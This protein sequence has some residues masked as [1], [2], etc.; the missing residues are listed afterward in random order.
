MPQRLSRI[1]ARNVWLLCISLGGANTV[2]R[3]LSAGLSILATQ[4]FNSLLLDVPQFLASWNSGWLQTTNHCNGCR[5]RVARTAKTP[6]QS[7]TRGILADWDG[8]E[9]L[10]GALP[11]VHHSLQG[12]QK[13]LRDDALVVDFDRD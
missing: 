6:W 9:Q 5:S 13:E 4:W 10:G 12:V 3:S 2:S 11:P 1:S 7:L 8:V